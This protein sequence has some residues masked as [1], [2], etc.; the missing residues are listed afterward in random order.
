MISQA[1]VA[2]IKHTNFTLESQ[3]AVLGAR[4]ANFVVSQDFIKINDKLF[5]CDITAVFGWII[6]FES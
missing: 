2:P 5:W 6:V 1:K 4:S 3:A